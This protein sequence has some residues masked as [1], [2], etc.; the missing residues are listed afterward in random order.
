MAQIFVFL[1]NLFP[2]PPPLPD[3]PLTHRKFITREDIEEMKN[4]LKGYR[5]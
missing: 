5:F 4:D 3:K 2:K 1:S